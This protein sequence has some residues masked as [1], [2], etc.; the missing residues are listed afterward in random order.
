MKKAVILLSGGLDSTTCLALAKAQGYE[1]YALS[2]SYGQRHSAELLAAE[3]IAR[4]FAV[5][6]HK[7][8]NLD[9]EL[10]A[11][12]ALTTDTVA[13]PLYEQSEEIPVTYV[14]ARNTIFLAMALGFA[15]SIGARDLFI[16]A[17]SIDY[18]HYPDCR[19]EFI[20]AFQ[21]LANLATKAGAEGSLFT[22]HAP[23]QHLSKLQTIELG[24][25]LGVDYSM[26]VSCYQANDQG[27][28]CGT[29]D[30]CTF[31]KKGFLAAQIADPTVYK[32]RY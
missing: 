13:V 31:R 20:A 18:S 9:T 10:F 8:V 7:I 3:R 17:S 4:H 19:P 12:S 23:L 5:V 27:E 30:S 14:P 25:E 32:D 1:C 24:L 16:G 26:T 21:T 28:A 22:V 15:E 2:F 6:S 11:G 29:C